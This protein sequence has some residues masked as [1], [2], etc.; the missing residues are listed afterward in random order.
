MVLLYLYK[1]WHQL[2]ISIKVCFPR[3][4]LI[5]IPLSGIHQICIPTFPFDPPTQS[6]TFVDVASVHTNIDFRQCLQS[7]H[8]FPEIM[9]REPANFMRY[10]NNYW[11]T[12]K[13][14]LT[15][16]WRYFCKNGSYRD[17][18]SQP[19]AQL[20]CPLLHWLGLQHSTDTWVDI[21]YLTVA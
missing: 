20:R 10:V 15:N 11:Y 6:G 21:T 8:Q 9:L 12:E 2:Q 7:R 19:P 5:C 3:V 1:E 14:E 18:N 13:V 16:F 17:P 4:Q